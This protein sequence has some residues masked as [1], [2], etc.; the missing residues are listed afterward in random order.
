MPS[1]DWLLAYLAEL[2]H[3]MAVDDDGVDPEGLDPLPEGL[4]VV[5]QRGRVRLAQPEQRLAQCT[6]EPRG[7]Q[8]D[9]KDYVCMG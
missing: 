9:N 7:D 6:K 1:I 3:V 4:H 5:L 8:F 2:L